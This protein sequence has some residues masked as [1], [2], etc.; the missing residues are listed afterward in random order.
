MKTP[1]A[2]VTKERLYDEFNTVVTETEQLLKSVAA[3]GSGQGEAL[4]ASAARATEEYVQ[5]NP[6]RAVGYVAA[7]AALTGLLAGLVLSRR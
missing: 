6:W 7:F 4:K 3:A 1:P 5:A 2:V